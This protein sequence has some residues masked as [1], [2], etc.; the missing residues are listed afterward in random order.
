[1]QH[2]VDH[3]AVP[4]NRKV[5]RRAIE[6][7]KLRRQFGNPTNEGQYQLLLRTLANVRD[8]ERAYCPAIISLVSNQSAN[9]DDGVVDVLW[10]FVSHRGADI[11]FAIAVM[12]IGSGESFEVRHRFDIPN[13]YACAHVSR[14]GLQV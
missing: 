12:A 7:N 14:P 13:D 4:Q 6:S 5:K 11:V 3:C 10:E 9:A 8:S 1:V 2:S